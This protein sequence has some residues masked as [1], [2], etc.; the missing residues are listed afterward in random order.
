MNFQKRVSLFVLPVLG[1]ALVWYASAPYRIGVSPDTMA[2]L[3]VAHHLQA[4]EGFSAY[5]P[6]F[7]DRSQPLA[8]WPPMFPLVIWSGMP[9]GVHPLDT[10]W[11]VNIALFGLNLLLMGWIVARSCRSAAAGWAAQSLFLLYGQWRD[12]FI[13]GVSEPLFLFLVHAALLFLLNYFESGRK[14]DLRIAALAVGCCEITRYIG[15][16]YIPAF[17]LGVLL[18]DKGNWT[19]RLQTAVRFFVLAAV[20]P[21]LWAVRN[22]LQLSFLGSDSRSWADR[23]FGSLMHRNEAVNSLGYNIRSAMDAC[24]IWIGGLFGRSITPQMN[25]WALALPFLAVAAAAAIRTVRRNEKSGSRVSAAVLGLLTCAY[26]IGLIGGLTFSLFSGGTPDRYLMPTATHAAMLMIILVCSDASPKIRIVLTV[27]FILWMGFAAM[28]TAR[29]VSKSRAMG[30][31][32][33][34]GGR[35]QYAKSTHWFP[36]PELVE[37]YR[38]KKAYE[39]KSFGMSF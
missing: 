35:W 34:Q 19:A 30:A 8:A 3:N 6:L 39:Q 16:V 5:Y 25:L 23:V 36:T 4:G 32:E 24:V 2:Y 9:F 26:T 1:I 37:Q 15:G 22:Y 10:A 20:I 18:Y 38:L 7:S 27:A 28:E 12:L 33:S 21:V 17:A 11:I 31:D 13:W 29:W 14:R